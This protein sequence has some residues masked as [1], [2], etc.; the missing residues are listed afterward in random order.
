MANIIRMLLSIGVII[1]FTGISS[2]NNSDINKED[3]KPIIE[4]FKAD[5]KSMNLGDRVRAA[6][7]IAKS[8]EIGLETRVQLLLDALKEEHSEP[9]SSELEQWTGYSTVTEYLKNTYILAL[10]DM[11]KGIVSILKDDYK[12]EK[13]ELKEK[14]TIVLGYLGDTAVHTELIVIIKKTKNPYT[15]SQAIRVSSD[16]GMGGKELIALYKEAL[17]D[18]FYVRPKSDL[19]LPPEQDYLNAYYPVREEAFSA[20]RKLGVNVRRDNNEFYVDSVE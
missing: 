7:K 19:I 10:K 11:G 13:G 9:Q 15:K 8:E 2:A 4:R 1:T 14:L 17:K 3:K 12:E 18:D 16:L 20:L 6:K 5:F